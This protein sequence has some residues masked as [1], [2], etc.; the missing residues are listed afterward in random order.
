MSNA[1]NGEHR[2]N[3]C[4]DYHRHIADGCC[5]CESAPVECPACWGDGYHDHDLGREICTKCWGTGRV[6][7]PADEDEA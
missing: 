1:E 5:H 4:C 7:Q 3:A 2:P 6:M